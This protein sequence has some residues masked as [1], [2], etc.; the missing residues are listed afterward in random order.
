MIAENVFFLKSGG[1]F[2]PLQILTLEI[3]DIQLDILIFGKFMYGASA[4]P[5]YF[6]QTGKKFNI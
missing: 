3:Q 5:P 4:V 6:Y 2:T 1:N